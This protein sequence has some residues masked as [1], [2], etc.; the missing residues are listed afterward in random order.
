MSCRGRCGWHIDRQNNSQNTITKIVE[1]SWRF[2]TVRHW[3]SAASRAQYVSTHMSRK[4]WR[5]CTPGSDLIVVGCL[6]YVFDSHTRLASLQR[7]HFWV[8]QGARVKKSLVCSRMKLE[9]PAKEEWKLAKFGW[10]LIILNSTFKMQKSMLW[11]GSLRLVLTV[12]SEKRFSSLGTF[13]KSLRLVFSDFIQSNAVIF[14]TNCSTNVS[15]SNSENEKWFSENF[16]KT[17]DSLVGQ[18]TWFARWPK[19]SKTQPFVLDR[20]SRWL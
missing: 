4:R 11:R 15:V 3:A 19:V 5:E 8:F 10:K 2:V 20:G 13:G 9:T 14:R 1:P 12:Q 6:T 17:R 18:N 7:G 16:W